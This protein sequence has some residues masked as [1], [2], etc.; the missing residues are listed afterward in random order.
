[1]IRQDRYA[2]GTLV[3]WFEAGLI[4]KLLGWLLVRGT[5]V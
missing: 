3:R 1:M 2:D 5:E 4:Q